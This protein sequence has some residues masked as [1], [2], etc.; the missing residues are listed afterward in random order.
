LI[1]NNLFLIM[2]F[3]ANFLFQKFIFLWQFY[4]LVNERYCSIWWRKHV[5]KAIFYSFHKKCLIIT[6]Y[7][8][9]L[10]F[11]YSVFTYLTTK[12]K[13][14]L[15]SP[16]NRGLLTTLDLQNISISHTTHT[17]IEE[18]ISSLYYQYSWAFSS[19]RINC[20]D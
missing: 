4:N 11:L 19:D 1:S 7:K 12:W 17:Y 9:L 6:E 13:K 2:Y 10:I 5:I 20:V 16:L 15:R 18:W 8:L 3:L 14:S